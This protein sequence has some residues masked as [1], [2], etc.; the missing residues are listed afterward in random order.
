MILPVGMIMKKRLLSCL[1]LSTLMSIGLFASLFNTSK[2]V[3]KTEGYST[4]SLPTKIDLND[5]SAADIRAYYDDLDDLTE[6]ERKGNNLL[7]NLKDILKKNQK[8][9]A[10]D[11]S[12]EGKKIWQI[13][14]ISDRDWT[15]SPASEISGYNANTNIITGYTYGT[16]YSSP[17]TNPYLHVLYVDRN[18]D[19]NMHAWKVE[20]RSTVNHG[21]NAQWCIDREHIWAKSEGFE[22][23]AQG[24]ARGD[25]MHLWPGDSDVN[26]SLHSNYFYGYVKNTSTSSA[27]WSYAKNNYMGQSLT[28]NQSSPNVF[29]P[30]DCDKGDI[31]RAIFYMVAR[32]NYLSGEDIDGINSNNPNLA[33]TQSLSDYASSGFDSTTTTQGKMG[34]LTD[35]LAWHKADPVDGFEIHRNNLLYKNFTNNRNPFIDFPEW[36]DYIWGTA[37]YNG[38]N[39]VS[40][41]STP[42]GCATPN[43]DTIN[44]Y[45]SGGTVSVSGVSV[46]PTQTSISVGGSTNL[47]ATVTP[48]N[49]TD[50]SV[51]WSTS[52]PSV[53]TVSNGTVTGVATGSATI[54]VTTTDGRYT[55]TCAVTVVDEDD[56]S[57]S[58]TINKDDYTSGYA[59]SGTSGTITKTIKSSNDLTINYS[60]I[61]T[62]SSNGGSYAYTMYISNNGYIYSSTCPSGYYP[63]NVVVTFSSSTGTT[64]KAGISYGTS[65]I[66]TR[67][68][69][70]TGSV[71]Q[72]GTCSL[73][74]NDSSKKYWN[75]STAN[76]NV[77]VSSI[78]VTYEPIPPVV[79]SITASV[80]NNKTF[81]V[82]DTITK[83]DI[84]VTTNLED[85]VTE[86]AAFESYTF[87]YAD[88]SSGG[89]LTNKTFTNG[90]S[91][92]TFTCNLT[93]QVQRKARANV[94]TVT[95]TLNRELTGIS[96]T[97]YSTWTNKTDQSDAVYSG[98]SAGGNNS[99]QLRTNNS[100]SGIISTSSGGVLRS[101]S[102]TWYSETISNRTINIYGKNS[103]YSSPSDLF[104]NSTST[105]GTLLGTIVKGK[106]TSL[107]IT[108]SYTF[109]G[110]RSADGALWLTEVEITY[111]EDDTAANVANYIMYEDTN[112]QCNSKTDIAIGYYNGLTS[113]EKTTF[114]TSSD[115]VISTARERFNAWLANKGKFIG[116]DYSIQGA[117]NINF[118]SETNITAVIVVIFSSVGVLSL[119]AYF[120][121]RR[122]KD[123]YHA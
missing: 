77:Q 24:G 3:E 113:S 118:I 13:Y 94:G 33:L 12:S 25:P 120:Y 123:S 84:T 38:R 96:T 39:Y 95:D 104:S 48:N 107:T 106:S 56:E 42:T 47:N 7:K 32:Y 64:G 99:I 14:E 60:G 5:T 21:D 1:S 22:T 59:Q 27:A 74:N 68:S 19:N 119:G 85:N 82:G 87:T 72:S 41:S 90:V 115:Y 37:T 117:K 28:L 61:N 10:Y 70:V 102:V 11:G 92:S 4:S 110:I 71:S 101:V 79:T 52:N 63:S 6:S 31:A 44:G 55:A 65:T 97:S 100:N 51:S 58:A 88:A 114:N 80:K 43:T 40:Y 45:N 111:G 2:E 50:S 93:V 17:G 66:S 53:A 86:D 30:Q 91:Y 89:A 73:S 109:I 83:S 34:I 105:S 62:Q 8:Y 36:V 67:N 54:T 20:G 16:S 26:S 57:V 49:A 108:G 35:L 121:F 15:K 69:S 122:K 46:S 18:V 9:Y 29:E 103:T 112:G 23:S 76:A 75:F 78:V 81:Y 98:Q 116:G